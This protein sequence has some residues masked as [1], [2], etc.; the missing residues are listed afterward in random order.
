MQ[1]RDQ[2]YAARAYTDVQARLR[3][4]GRN[5]AAIDQYGGMAHKLPV[6]IRTAG[7]AQALAFVAR[8]KEPHKHLLEDVERAIDRTDGATLADASRNA[9]LPE[10]MRLT[11]E[12]LAALLWYKRYAESVMGVEDASAAEVATQ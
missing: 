1:T 5:Q 4:Y 7:L 11:Q 6:L 10:Y 2:K 12:V 3:E 9:E 8:S